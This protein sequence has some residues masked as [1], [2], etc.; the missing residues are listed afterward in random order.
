MMSAAHI[1]P[2]HFGQNVTEFIFHC[3]QCSL[4]SICVLLTEGVEMQ[5]VKQGSQFLRHVLVPFISCDSK[6][7]A[8]R[9]RIINGMVFLGGTFRVDTEPHTLSAGLRPPAKLF[10]LPHRIKYNMVC[11]AQ[12][13]FKLF[14]SVSTAK[15]VDFLARHFFCPK[16]RLKKTAGFRS[17][18]GPS[19]Q[20]IKIIVGKG[21]LCQ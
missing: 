8:R 7:A 12:Q 17:C 2:L 5:T 1:Q 18:K 19:Q 21:F 9:T 3:C 16:A 6:A 20:R 14:F 13:F 11:I 10:K 4:Q 15:H